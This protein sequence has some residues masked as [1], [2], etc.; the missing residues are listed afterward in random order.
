M[1]GPANLK[2]KTY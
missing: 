1:T 2:W